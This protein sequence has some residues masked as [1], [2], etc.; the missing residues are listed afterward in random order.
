MKIPEI[1]KSI[2]DYTMSED[3]KIS[4]QAII[5]MGAVLGSA[6]L[7]LMNSEDAVAHGNS[8]TNNFSLQ[9]INDRALGQHTHHASY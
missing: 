9:V 2:K 3:S 6:A 8:H 4:K 5:T 7:G 1:K